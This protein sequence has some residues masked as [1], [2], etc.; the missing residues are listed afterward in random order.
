MQALLASK[1]R[2]SS[3]LQDTVYDLPSIQF[4]SFYPIR[5]QC[6]GT[7]TLTVRYLVLNRAVELQWSLERRLWPIT[8]V[9]VAVGA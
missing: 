4:M 3:T 9:V 7:C 8:R 6:L 2:N 5:S 1:R